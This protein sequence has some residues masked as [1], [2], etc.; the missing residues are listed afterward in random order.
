[1]LISPVHVL[2]LPEF[3]RVFLPVNKSFFFCFLFFARDYK[4]FTITYFWLMKLI[5]I[6][7]MWFQLQ[8]KTS[9]AKLANGKW[10][11]NPLRS[12]ENNFEGIGIDSFTS[13]RQQVP[14]Q[15]EPTGICQWRLLS[16]LA[17]KKGCYLR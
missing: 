17:N 2:A 4:L 3:I 13:W 16:I 12:S 14:A 10:M 6:I 7:K 8:N 1:M 15:A 5:I 9:I 11:I